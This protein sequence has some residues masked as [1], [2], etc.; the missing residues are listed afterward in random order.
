MGLASEEFAGKRHYT[1][2]KKKE[3]EQDHTA[4]F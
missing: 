2:V 3:K 1:G 4:K